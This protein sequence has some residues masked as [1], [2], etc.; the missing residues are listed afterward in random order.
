MADGAQVAE[1]AAHRRGR[2]LERPN[3]SSDSRETG[4][5]S[6]GLDVSRDGYVYLP[7]RYEPDQP[8]PFVLMLHG[9]GGNGRSGLAPL[10][11]LA[12]A[13]GLIL[14]APDAR[15]QT[16]D[17]LYDEY[18]PDPD[19][20]DRALAQTFGRYKVD[21]ERVAVEGFSDGASYA[22]SLGV[23]NGDLFTHVIAYSPGFMVPLDRR[24]S[25][26][27]FISHGVHDATLPI[28][29]CSRRL[30]PALERGGYD[31]TY[32]EFDGPHTVP[33]DV[34]ARS[35]DWFLASPSNRGVE[36]VRREER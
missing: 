31:V 23:A 19:F 6:L 16:W 27:I 29:R 14:L 2:L 30:A 33:P 15:W 17:V 5:F 24:G 7:R 10:L 28:E 8:A 36:A 11:S 26:R 34:A 20:I 21:P 35:I 9:A 1:A 13:A 18:G 25:P 12:D 32:V 4:L 3:G 22:L